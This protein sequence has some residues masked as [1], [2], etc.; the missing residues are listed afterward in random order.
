M[1]S[2]IKLLIKGMSCGRCV[3]E[4]KDALEGVYGVEQ[5]A[6]SMVKGTA[7]IT[8]DENIVGKERFIQTINDIGFESDS[9]Q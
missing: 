3:K 5:V 9:D 8:Y 7:R 6:L 4:A 2:E 1:A